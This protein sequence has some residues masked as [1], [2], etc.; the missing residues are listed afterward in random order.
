MKEEYENIALIVGAGA[1]ENAWKP[2][3]DFLS[4]VIPE[5]TDSDSANCFFSRYIYL[6]RFYATGTFPNADKQLKDLLDNFQEMKSEIAK[7]LIRAEKNGTIKPRAEFENILYEFIF[8]SKNKSVLFSTNWDTVIDNYINVVG[9]CDTPLLENNIPT[10]HV[11]GC[12]NTP[13]DFYFPSEIV[14]EPYRS[15]EDNNRMSNNHGSMWQTLEKCNK[16]II[17]GLSLDPLDAEL[18]QTLA[19]GFSSPNIREILVIN[20]S[21]EKVCKRIKLLIDPR[22]PVKVSG[23]SPKDLK[24]IS[25]Y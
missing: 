24:K 20:P 19:A 8:S 6:L 1:V 14:K 2:I 12:V 17:Y 9:M 11:H 7:E 15:L 18:S 4:E 5:I 23:C 16:A 3:V 22:F 13:E 25:Y 21:F 10:Y